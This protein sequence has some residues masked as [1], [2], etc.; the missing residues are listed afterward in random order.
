MKLTVR[1]EQLIGNIAQKKKKN[2]TQIITKGTNFTLKKDDG[3]LR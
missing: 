3:V 1:I 2:D